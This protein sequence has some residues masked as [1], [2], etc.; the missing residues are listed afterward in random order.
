MAPS[1]AVVKAATR[2]LSPLD[3]LDPE[4][5]QRVEELVAHSLSPNT[6]KT[7][8]SHLAGFAKWCRDKGYEYMPAGDQTVAAYLGHLSKR[9]RPE[10]GQPCRPS[11]IKSVKSAIATAHR[12]AGHPDPTKTE[13][14]LRTVAGINRDLKSGQVKRARAATADEILAMADVQTGNH[15][16]DLRAAAAVLI[17]FGGCMRRS[18]VVA[19]N[20]EDIRRRRDG[21]VCAFIAQ[22]KTDQT[23][24]GEEVPLPLEAVDAVNAWLKA[25]GITSGPIFRKFGRNNTILP[26]ALTGQAVR[27]IVKERAAMAGLKPLDHEPQ[28]S[29]HSLRRGAATEADANDATEIEI[30]R[31]GR[32][33]S[34]QTVSMYVDKSKHRRYVGEI[35]GLKKRPTTEETA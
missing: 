5:R 19:L 10:T 24:E 20:V 14:V 6:M 9:P 1:K 3:L 35:L 32:W 26:R 30:M 12:I 22:S 23:G 8:R 13:L 25:A 15:L 18:E 31:L 16:V 27:L 2:G 34:M 21:S 28:W 29:G 4:D 11:T 7:Y 17:G 33:K